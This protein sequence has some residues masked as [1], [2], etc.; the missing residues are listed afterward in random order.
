MFRRLVLNGQL[1]SRLQMSAHT[2]C[3]RQHLYQAKDH[4]DEKPEPHDQLHPTVYLAE[5]N[6]DHGREEAVCIGLLAFAS[7]VDKRTAGLKQG[8]GTLC[9]FWRSGCNAKDG[10]HAFLRGMDVLAQQCRAA[11]H[12]NNK[13]VRPLQS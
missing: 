10:C 3:S 8:N 9:D 12:H 1:R 5:R 4:Q 13:G 11:V 6:P 7:K 2:S